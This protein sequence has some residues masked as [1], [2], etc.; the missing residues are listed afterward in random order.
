MKI[1]ID[2]DYKCHTT[3]LDGT[4]REVETEFFDGKC[5]AFIEGYMFVPSGETWVREDGDKFVGEMICPL[6]DYNEL[7]AIQR[8]YERQLL[9]D[10]EAALAQSVR[11]S[12]L[13]AAYQEGV[14]AAY[15][16]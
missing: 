13:D 11:L 5:V 1:Y 12:D 7:D 14:N 9:A 3:N 2:S 15:D 6:N 16:Q 8:E 10:Y 4:F